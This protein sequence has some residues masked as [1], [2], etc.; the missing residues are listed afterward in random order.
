MF[1]GLGN[2]IPP[3]MT[4]FGRM[5]VISIAVIVFSQMAGFE[6]RWIWYLSTVSVWLHLSA[7]LLL[8]RRE[9]RI[10]LPDPEAV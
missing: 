2:T 1:Q 7:N 3:L 6:L 5:C 9:L 8:L 4:S 10:R